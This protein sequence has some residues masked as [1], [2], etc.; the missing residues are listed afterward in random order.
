MSHHNIEMNQF[1]TQERVFFNTRQQDII[2]KQIRTKKTEMLPYLK[3]GQLIPYPVENQ[4]RLLHGDRLDVQVPSQI[5][6]PP[7]EANTAYWSQPYIPYTLSMT[8]N[9]L[10]D[11]AGTYYINKD[12]PVMSRRL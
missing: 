3:L 9:K 1:A 2:E 7:I 10:V 6:R 11:V 4:F 12:L 8:N 5:I